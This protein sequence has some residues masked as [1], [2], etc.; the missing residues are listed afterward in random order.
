MW[1]AVAAVAGVL[2]VGALAAMGLA[3]RIDA[4][5]LQV[6]VVAGM[7][8][9]GT[10]HGASIVHV[11]FRLADPP[12]L[13]Q[14]DSPGSQPRTKP[15]LAPPQGT[16]RGGSMIGVL[17]RASSIL[18]I[19]VAE[20]TILAAIVAIKAVGRFGELSGDGLGAAARMRERFLVGSLASLTIA[21][22]WG[23][24]ASLLVR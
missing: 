24:A 19:V 16:M 12:R 23:V 15:D 7:T 14:L 4:A 18:A 9:A 21:G 17:E 10:A 13:A 8:A 2:A 20:P 5:W 1:H 11:V 3:W 22:V 6:L